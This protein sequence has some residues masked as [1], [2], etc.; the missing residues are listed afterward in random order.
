MKGRRAEG[1]P[2]QET[3]QHLQLKR[4]QKKWTGKA[5]AQISPAQPHPAITLM[6]CASRKCPA[7]LQGLLGKYG[8]EGPSELAP[9]SGQVCNSYGLVA[10]C[11][12][13]DVNTHTM[14]CRAQN[15]VLLT[16]ELTGH[17]GLLVQDGHHSGHRGIF[18]KSSSWGA[19]RAW[20]CQNGAKT[21]VLGTNVVH[22]GSTGPP[23]MPS[24]SIEI[25]EIGLWLSR[26]PRY[27]E[28]ANVHAGSCRLRLS[29][30]DLLSSWIFNENFL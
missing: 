13:S 10:A 6:L 4:W 28:D 22:A 8:P 2:R 25:W 29:D 12:K 11:S 17:S 26:P 9:G 3:R 16:P 23:A 21:G 1:E 5:G 15:G 18:Q 20:A 19:R 30:G 27:A 24:L 7:L 14:H